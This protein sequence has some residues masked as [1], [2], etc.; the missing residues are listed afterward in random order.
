MQE[1]ERNQRPE[2]FLPSDTDKVAVDA[3]QVEHD[4]GADGEAKGGQGEH[5]QHP[6]L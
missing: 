2:S 3:L 4:E 5:Q 1:S 6:H